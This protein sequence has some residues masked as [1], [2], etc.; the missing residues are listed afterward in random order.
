M[1]TAKR[2]KAGRRRRS[3]TSEEVQHFH[4][5]FITNVTTLASGSS[6]AAVLINSLSSLSTRLADLAVIYD[7]VR[8]RRITVRFLNSGTGASE[9]GFAGYV[10]GQVTNQP[11]THAEVAEFERYCVAL[12]GQTTPCEMTLG[13]EVLAGRQPWYDIGGTDSHTGRFYF[14]AYT[15]GNTLA[16]ADTL[17]V[18]FDV[19][20]SLKGMTEAA[21]AMSKLRKRAQPPD[22]PRLIIDTHAESVDRQ[23]RYVLV[24]DEKS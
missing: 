14:G 7:K 18:V 3:R 11:T 24:H 2:P 23:P 13:A 1:P 15:P 20:F 16:T 22:T 21:V 5:R 8:Y 6:Q 9:P 10:E 17:M 4:C 19:H 12:P